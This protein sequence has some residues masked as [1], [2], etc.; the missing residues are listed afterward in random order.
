MSI[1]QDI[2]LDH[3]RNPR[4]KRALENPT[5]SSDLRNPLCGDVIHVDIRMK[6]GIVQ[7]IGFEGTGCAIS[8]ASASMM[9]EYAMGKSNEALK[10]IDK[11]FIVEMLGLSL[12]PTRLKCALLA[13]EAL[14]RALP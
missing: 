9:T 13:W 1:Y 11:D 4:N 8:Q 3:Y 12:S 2:I 14:A 5:G 7:D 10:K 6:D